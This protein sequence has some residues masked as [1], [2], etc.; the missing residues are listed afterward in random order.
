MSNPSYIAQSST[1]MT[2]MAIISSAIMFS[3]QMA[4]AEPFVSS[5]TAKPAFGEAFHNAL[6]VGPDVSGRYR[7]HVTTTTGYLALAAQQAK[8][9]YQPFEPSAADLEPWLWVVV[10]P[11][12]PYLSN[13]T[14]TITPPAEVVVLRSKTKADDPPVL[15]ATTSTTDQIVWQNLLGATFTGTVV[16]LQFDPDDAMSLLSVADVDVVIVTTAGERRC[17]IGKGDRRNLLRAMDD[18]R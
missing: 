2:S 17:K 9:T 10:V 15:Q 14:L 13:G 12:D 6:R 5:C 4:G 18:E 3:A 8:R 1:M 7:V 11:E 16:T